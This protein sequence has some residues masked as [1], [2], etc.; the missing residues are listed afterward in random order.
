M[1]ENAS[2][3]L[4]IVDAEENYYVLPREAV[5]TAKAAPG[6][7]AAIEAH[8]REQIKVPLAD[9]YCFAGMLDLPAGDELAHYT[10]EA[11]WPV[12]TTS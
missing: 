1:P 8:L 7:K 3:A 9:G 12:A 2:Q 6:A 4:V 10:T 5:E 11:S